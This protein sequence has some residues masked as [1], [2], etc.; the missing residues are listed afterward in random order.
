MIRNANRACLRLAGDT[1]DPVS[2]NNKPDGRK[3]GWER[4]PSGYDITIVIMTISIAGSCSYLQGA[5]MK[6]GP[7]SN[8]G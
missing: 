3:G 2:N 5:L 1:G 8:H 7:I 6:L 4:L